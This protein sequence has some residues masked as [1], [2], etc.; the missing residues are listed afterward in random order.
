MPRLNRRRFLQLAGVGAGAVL[1]ACA[2][3]VVTLVD[4]PTPVPIS[5]TDLAADKQVLLD[6]REALRVRNFRPLPT[7]NAD[8][9]VNDFEGITVDGN[10]G[11]VTG[12]NLELL[13]AN[14]QILIPPELGQL[15]N[16]KELSFCCTVTGPIPPELGQLR[17]L[18]YL[19]LRGNQLPGLSPG[20]LT[21]SIPPELGQLRNL[22][23]L[24]LR[25][26]RLTGSIP[27]E[28]G[29]LRN[30]EYLNLR[31]N[32]LTGSIPLELGQLRNLEYLDLDGNQL[33]GSIPLELGQLQNLEYLDL[34]GNQL[35]GSIPLELGQLQNLEYLDLRGN[36]LTGCVPRNLEPNLEPFREGASLPLCW[37]PG[38]LPGR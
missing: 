20:R 26:N 15:Q 23:Y 12:I 9:P 16:L 35:T 33:T 31:G 7:W 6:I 34:D 13:W 14:G 36:R 1:A 19:D 10:P 3:A 28:L 21:G 2:E 24:D 27:P 17:N 25:G 30:L 18:E 11:R 22:E 38:D 5:A 37:R 29:Q 4:E 32:R 8:T